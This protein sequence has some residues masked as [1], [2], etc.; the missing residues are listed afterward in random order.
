MSRNLRLTHLLFLM[1]IIP[2]FTITVSGAASPE[3]AAP[4]V[5][6]SVVVSAER[7]REFVAHHPQEVHEVG[8]REIA[9]RHL[10]SVEEILRTMPGVD[11]VSTTGIGSRISIR[12]SGQSGGVLV[13]VNGR[14]LNA[15][16]Y[17]TQDLG[18]IP[19]D[20]IRSV[21]VFKPPAPVWL[22]P[23][24]SN[25]AINIVT[26]PETKE[27]K[28]EEAK[29]SSTVKAS[30]GSYGLGEGSLSHQLPLAGGTALLAGGASHR[31]GRRE[32]SDKDTQSLALNWNRH[33]KS[34]S[35]IEAGGRLN[36]AEYG[37]PGPLD[38]LTPL[39][40]QDYRKGSLETKYT[41]GLGEAGTFSALVYGDALSLEDRSQSGLRAT[42]DDRKLGLKADG[43]WSRDDG[44]G[45]LRLGLLSEGDAF[46]HT[47][48]GD[49]T[50]FRNGISGQVDRSFGVLT[51]SVGLRGDLTNDF[52][53]APG[54]QMGLGWS[55]T[56][57][58]LL[59]LKTGYTVNVPTFEQLYQTTHGSIDQSRGNPNLNEERVVNSGLG[60]E[61]T[62]A[63]DRSLQA[64]LFRADT[65]DLIVA[66]RGADLIYRPVNLD[67]GLRQGLELIGRYGWTGGPVVDCSL[68]LQ[69]SENVATGKEL[70]YTPAVKA[71]STLQYTLARSKTR[72]ESTLRY[73]GSRYGRL[74]NL[75]DER[76]ASY[77][78]VDLKATQPFPL[79]GL[80]A[81]GYLKVENLFDAAYETHLGYPADGLLALAGMQVK[82]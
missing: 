48:A 72:L 27:N 32:N 73:E 78:A 64:V 11:V 61:Y 66:E 4:V 69:E 45:D 9:E 37:S 67:R 51:P 54:G 46:E 53:F 35:Q 41:G 76:L 34:G 62:F 14:P 22:G 52:G 29:P 19:V 58:W 65:E 59:K 31:D 81:E 25:G 42:L 1:L 44:T 77:G 16:Q 24:G 40:R 82:F 79:H 50:R 21:T 10:G 56:K 36:H 55:L 49:H 7:L 20:A 18:T 70:P 28:G 15:N 2:F 3:E 12:G 60:L 26:A 80:A 38:N 5:L 68:I 23:G 71:K 13:L 39:A 30:A 43:T 8:R 57:E 75:P 47:L 63:K 74:E 6:G 33:Q 17:G